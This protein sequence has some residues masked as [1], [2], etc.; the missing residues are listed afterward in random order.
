MDMFGVLGTLRLPS[1]MGP[2]Q[3]SGPKVRTICAMLLLPANQ[4]VSMEC[5]A[6]ELWSGTPP[7]TAA[8]TVRTHIYHLRQILGAY[9]AGQGTPVITEPG[10]YRLRLPADSVDAQVFRRLA[11]EGRQALERGETVYAASV[12]AEAQALWRGSALSDVVTGRLL[13]EQRAHLEETRIQ[14][15]ECRIE[16]DLRLGRHRRLLPELRSLVAAY[17]FNE[18]FHLRYIEALYVCG[19]RGDALQAVSLIRRLLKE[20]LG[21]DPSAQLHQLQQRILSGREVRYAEPVAHG[22][23]PAH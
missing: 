15:L 1:D 13:S 23:R 14:V 12:L 7:A 2:G 17:P 3:L 6:E 19:R 16:A 4:T 21:L 5:L 9:P 10:G 20:E 18:W 8:A 11:A 22:G